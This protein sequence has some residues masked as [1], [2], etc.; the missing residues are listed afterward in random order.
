M[1]ENHVHIQFPDAKFSVKR[2]RGEKSQHQTHPKMKTSSIINLILPVEFNK[3][4]AS[5]TLRST[6][7]LCSQKLNMI[8]RITQKLND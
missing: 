3:S 2:K 1:D 5:P 7:E 8:L 4:K 6:A